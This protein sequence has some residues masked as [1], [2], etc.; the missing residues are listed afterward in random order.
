MGSAV[1]PPLVSTLLLLLGWRVAIVVVC[2]PALLLLNYVGN[3]MPATRPPSIPT[4]HRR[5]WPSWTRGRAPPAAARVNLARVGRL[6]TNPQIV[7][8]TTSYFLTNY[9]FYLV[10][11]WSFIYLSAGTAPDRARAWLAQLA[12]H[13]SPQPSPAPRVVASAATSACTP[14]ITVG[15]ARRYHCWRC[16]QQ[17]S[18]FP[19][20]Y[21]RRAERL[22]VGSSVVPCLRLV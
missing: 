14:R 17:R 22:C 12:F 10:M 6:L 15:N 8:I 20:L 9:V 11:F 3:A 19:W 5:N 21:R 1:T 13:S 7:M 18:S 16:H 4:C 2:V